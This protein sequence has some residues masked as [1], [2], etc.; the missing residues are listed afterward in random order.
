[1][2]NTLLCLLVFVA[3]LDGMGIQNS[4]ADIT[5]LVK[6]SRHTALQYVDTDKGKS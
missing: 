3:F 2:L 6:S 5:R 4:T 1:M